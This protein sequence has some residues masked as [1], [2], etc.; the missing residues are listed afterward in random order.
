MASA[1][2]SP[3]PAP[4]AAPGISTDFRKLDVSGGYQVRVRKGSTFRVTARGPQRMLD[5]AQ[6]RVTNGTLEI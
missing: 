5:D 6:L 4:P 3:T 2:A 1:C